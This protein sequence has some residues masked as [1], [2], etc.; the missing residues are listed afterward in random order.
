MAGEFQYVQETIKSYLL[1]HNPTSCP[2]VF[3]NDKQ[4]PDPNVD[5]IEVYVREVYNKALSK[6]APGNNHWRMGGSLALVIKGQKDVGTV[7]TSSYADKFRTLL[8]GNHINNVVFGASEAKGAGVKGAFYVKNL[9]T[10]FKYD[11][12]G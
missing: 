4:K 5:Q 10:D 7:T 1:A 6:G 3:E 8:Q 2:L 12:Y 11:Y 9:L